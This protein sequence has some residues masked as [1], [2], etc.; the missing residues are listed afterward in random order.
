MTK[1]LN[2]HCILWIYST[3]TDIE[4]KLKEVLQKIEIDKVYVR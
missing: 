4:K 1:K 3:L 2:G